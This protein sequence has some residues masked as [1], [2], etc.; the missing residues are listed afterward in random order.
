MAENSSKT[1]RLRET[2]WAILMLICMGLVVLHLV[3]AVQPQ[4]VQDEGLIER[5]FTAAGPPG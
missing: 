2:V 3:E 1:S 5:T 4:S